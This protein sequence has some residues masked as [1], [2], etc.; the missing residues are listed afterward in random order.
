MP[1]NYPVSIDLL[2]T[3]RR[4]GLPP[5]GEPVDANDI[6][7]IARY[8]NAIAT[9]LGVNPS[10]PYADVAARLAELRK[11][12]AGV[13]SDASFAATPT[14]GAI[15]VN[16]TTGQLLV[17]SG[18]QWL[19][20]GGSQQLFVAA[21][22]AP[23]I[24]KSSAD[25]VC[26]GI[27]DE[28]EVNAALAALPAT[29][30]VVQLSSGAFNVAPTATINHV[31]NAEL[32]GQGRGATAV[33]FGDGS[34]YGILG[35]GTLGAATSL[36]ADATEGILTLTMA[37]SAGFAAGDYV[38]LDSTVNTDGDH[39]GRVASTTGTTVVLTDPLPIILT[40][41]S[42]AR[43]RKLTPIKNARVA[44]MTLSCAWGGT[45]TRQRLLGYLNAI[46]C[47]AER[48]S[49]TFTGG[50]G[51]VS[52]SAFFASVG[53]NIVARDCVADGVL[54]TTNGIAY[55]FNAVTGGGVYGCVARNSSGGISFEN[56]PQSTAQGNRCYGVSSSGGRGIKVVFPGT[57][58]VIQGNIVS[59]YL[60]SNFT[61]I[62]IDDAWGCAVV[63]NVVRDCGGPGI[64][65]TGSV[66]G[67]QHHSVVQGNTVRRTCLGTTFQAAVG[68]GGGTGGGSV[69]T[70]HI[71][72]DNN[73]SNTAPGGA[74]TVRGIQVTS[75][76]NLIRGNL[77]DTVP[78]DG[79]TLDTAG[80]T[81]NVVSGNTILGVGVKTISDTSS[82]GGN[83]IGLNTFTQ[84]ANLHASDIS[85]GS[86][87]VSAVTQTGGGTL[88][89]DASL[90]D[91]VVV[92]VTDTTAFA[93]GAPTNK[94]K[95]AKL[96]FVILNSSGGAMGAIT[97]NGAF[98]LAGAFTNPASTKRRTIRFVCDGAN[99]IEESVT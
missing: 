81:S 82:A 18:G 21:S 77:I 10:G 23:Q 59:G 15:G 72:A 99:W 48:V 70:S 22:T 32:R 5:V 28:V 19:K 16:T 80:V 74:T 73:I 94:M 55:R 85:H 50:E 33:A 64:N 62:Q 6:N 26:D 46:D 17:R 40:V 95:D 25:Y 86:P 69:V 7:D 44:D 78:G 45:P 13:V 79:I 66:A 92:T 47:S 3:D 71:C 43:L 98:L 35:T 1:I 42:G 65:L 52:P 96:S 34:T 58:S 27:A 61:G 49:L 63:G 39:V 68:I 93:I 84:A 67:Q 38:L 83:V 91:T 90:Y 88:A 36:T 57:G 8:A 87:G 41:A 75:S 97:W 29:G 24:L 37:S 60:N 12:V 54:K 11:S 53:R 14:D 2:R 51:V 76:G 89:I 56:S 30:G 20:A 9:E 31:S 4:N